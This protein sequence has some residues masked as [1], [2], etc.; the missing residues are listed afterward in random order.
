MI[1]LWP[2]FDDW[3]CALAGC[4]VSYLCLFPLMSVLIARRIGNT[5]RRANRDRWQE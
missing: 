1:F 4:L 5:L 2:L 3:R